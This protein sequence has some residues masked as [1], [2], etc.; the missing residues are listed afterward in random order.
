MCV[1]I[2]TK[3]LISRNTIQ[4]TNESTLSHFLFCIF[5]T[6]NHCLITSGSNF[7]VKSLNNTDLFPET[8][9]QQKCT[10]ND[11]NR[12]LHDSLNIKCIYIPGRRRNI[13]VMFLK[14]HFVYVYGTM[15]YF[16]IELRIYYE[17]I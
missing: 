11:E 16:Y 7:A 6:L 15:K 1:K 12:K 14:M 10:N 13:S 2:D 9:V 17:E 3:S 5:I 8:N 4:M